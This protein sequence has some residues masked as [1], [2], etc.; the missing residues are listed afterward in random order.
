MEGEVDAKGVDKVEGRGVLE[1]V[2]E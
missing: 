1:G 2:G